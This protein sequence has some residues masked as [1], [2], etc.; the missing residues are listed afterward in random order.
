[1]FGDLLHKSVSVW[2]LG[3]EK[4]FQSFFSSLARNV[5]RLFFCLYILSVLFEI[6]PPFE[7]SRFVYVEEKKEKDSSV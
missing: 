6:S 3:S 4:K 2:R 7:N 5:L 1:M